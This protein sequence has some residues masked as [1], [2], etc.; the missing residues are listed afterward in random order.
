MPDWL[1]ARLTS[2][3]VLLAVDVEGMKTQFRSVLLQCWGAGEANKVYRGCL[4]FS[5]VG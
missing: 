5:V 4:D 1:E 3:M 2:L